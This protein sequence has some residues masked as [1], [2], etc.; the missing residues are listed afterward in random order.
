MFMVMF[1]IMFMLMVIYVYDYVYGYVMFMIMFMVIYVYGYVGCSR[2]LRRPPGDTQETPR[3]RQE[4]PGGGRGRLS[5]S[6]VKSWLP[7]R[8]SREIVAQVRL[9]KPL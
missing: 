9:A 7:V 5:G 1:M 2:L 4:A 3:R 8:L 6:P